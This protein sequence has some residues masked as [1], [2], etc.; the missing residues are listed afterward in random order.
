MDFNV[1]PNF[2]VAGP[3]FES[4]INAFR[5]ALT[6]LDNNQINDLY[7]GKSITLNISGKDMEI[8]SEMV[9]IRI[10]SKEGF[11]ASMQNNNF[12]I[13]NTT[14]T[15]DLLDEGIARELISKVQQMR[16][17][18]NFD[19]IDRINIYHNGNDE[20][21]R[22]IA[23]HEDFIKQETLAENIIFK[24]NAS[25]QVNLNGLDVALEVSRI[26]N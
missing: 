22:V 26:N 24:D 20:F 13:L 14:L 3:I 16:K 4:N 23:K 2:K 19:V 21:K 11:N 17:S 15:Q 7:N 12:I 18:S 5:E 9:E 25:E 8:T 10:I 6:N 1:L